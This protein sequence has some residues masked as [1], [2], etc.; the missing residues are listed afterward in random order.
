MDRVSLAGIELPNGNSIRGVLKLPASGVIVLEGQNGIGKSSLL[1][2]L[3]TS[4]LIKRACVFCHQFPWQ[5]LPHLRGKDLLSF[6]QSPKSQ[7]GSR[8]QQDI[9]K[10]IPIDSILRRPYGVL[11]GGER[12]LLKIYFYAGIESQVYFL[13]EPLA[14]LDPVNC[15]KFAQV[16]KGLAGEVL[17]VICEQNLGKLFTPD[18]TYQ[19]REKDGAVLELVLKAPEMEPK[20]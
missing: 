4:S 8:F 14:F 11:S 6:C 7:W 2:A 12:Q 10:K 19:L 20:Q 9:A 13:D 3:Q 17:F 18:F 16:L 15:A 5:P 1:R